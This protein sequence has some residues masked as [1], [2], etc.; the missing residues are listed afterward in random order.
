MGVFHLIWGSWV[1]Y[2]VFS[3]Y[4]NSVCGLLDSSCYL[5]FF[6]IISILFPLHSCGI[7]WFIK[8]LV[9][10]GLMD[11][12]IIVWD[13]EWSWVCFVFLWGLI[14]FSWDY[15]LLLFEDWLVSNIVPK[16]ELGV[17]CWV[18]IFKLI[19]RINGIFFKILQSFLDE[20]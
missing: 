6:V 2:W 14:F 10:W 5:I 8:L 13:F 17:L 19:F 20:V 4:G 12:T 7:E 11:F 1:L 3:F 15:C 16:Y 9:F 18:F